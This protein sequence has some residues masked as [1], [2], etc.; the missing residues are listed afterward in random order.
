MTINFRVC[1]ISRSMRKLTQ[2]FILI[3]IKK[4][5][6]V[7]QISNHM[8]KNIKIINLLFFKKQIIKK[9]STKYSN[10]IVK[11]CSIYTLNVDHQYMMKPLNYLSISFSCTKYYSIDD[12]RWS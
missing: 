2:I 11:Q 10:Y 8:K 7:F 3:I 1:R 5:F 12:M 6:S 4:I 9:Q